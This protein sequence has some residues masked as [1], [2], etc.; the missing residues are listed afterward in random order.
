MGNSRQ[1]WRFADGRVAIPDGSRRR[2]DGF[3]SVLLGIK[4]QAA[5]T[6]QSGP[7]GSEGEQSGMVPVVH[8]GSSSGEQG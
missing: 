5:E 7:G 2:G 8:V 3:V 4:T 1:V 6:C